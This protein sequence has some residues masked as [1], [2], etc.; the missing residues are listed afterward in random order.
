V[1]A[2]PCTSVFEGLEKG[3]VPH[4]LPDENPYLKELRSR[5]GLRPDA[6]TGGPSTMYPEYQKTLV[7]SDWSA[8][9]KKGA[10]GAARPQGGAAR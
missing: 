6:P 9:D 4:Y 7:P 3:Q 5:Y 2:H 1:P 8:G 10:A